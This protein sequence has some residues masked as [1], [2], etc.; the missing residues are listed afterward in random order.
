M[1]MR[2]RHRPYDFR[3]DG[4]LYR[5]INRRPG[6]RR[7]VTMPERGVGPHVR[8]VFAEMMRQQ[9]TYDEVESASGFRRAS[10]KGWRNKN[11]PGLDSLEAVLNSLGFH[12]IAVP[13]HVEMLPPSVAAKAAELAALAKIELGEVWSAAVQIAALQ[14]ASTAEGERILAELDAERAA[15]NDNKRHYRRKSK[16]A[17]DNAKQ[18]T[19][20]A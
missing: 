6:Y 12:L 5:F 2:S 4:P 15:A 9:R 17:N 1:K 8:L 11:A 14:L 16:P 3:E 7:T 13:A 19:T 20:A 18:A 10:L